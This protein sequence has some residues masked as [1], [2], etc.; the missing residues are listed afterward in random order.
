MLLTNDALET[1]K[2]DLFPLA[3]LITPNIP[4]VRA[5]TG[6]QVESLQDVR[7]AAVELLGFGSKAVLVKGG[8]TI[9]SS[10]LDDSC[11]DILLDSQGWEV[12]AKPRLNTS[13]THGT[14]CT[15]ASAICAYLAKGYALRDA[16]AKAKEYVFSCMENSF[17]IG[18]GH[19]PLNHGFYMTDGNSSQA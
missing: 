6:R 15:T 14:G 8:H 12:Y 10:E 17:S 2:R 4:E 5:L 9:A 3:T 16:V 11:T 7:E 18:S 19:G 1:L 13:N